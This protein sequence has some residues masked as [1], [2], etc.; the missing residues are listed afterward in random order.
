VLLI[1]VLIG[2][3]INTEILNRYRTRMR[4]EAQYEALPESN[5]EIVLVYQKA[6]KALAR[7]GFLRA[8]H[9]TPTEYRLA[10]ADRLPASSDAGILLDELTQLHQRFAY[11]NTMARPADVFAARAALDRLTASIALLPPSVPA[12]RQGTA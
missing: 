12:Q 10:I 11:G 5:M 3:V 9:L 1:L 4:V 2:Y 6:C 8:M 7:C